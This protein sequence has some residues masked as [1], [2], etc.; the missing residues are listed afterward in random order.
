MSI[1]SVNLKSRLWRSKKF[2][3]ATH[4][5]E[6][7]KP[8][9]IRSLRLGNKA[10]VVVVCITSIIM[11]LSIFVVLENAMNNGSVTPINSTNPPNG[12]S[13]SQI[14]TV[15]N[16]PGTSNS[17]PGDLPR[18]ISPTDNSHRS[19]AAGIIEKAQVMNSSVWRAVAQQAWQYFQIGTGV[20]STTGLPAAGIGYNYFTD[21][22]LG[23]YVQAVLDAQKI[24][25]ITKD[26]DWGSDYRLD[27]AL[28]FLETRPL[29]E[30]TNYPFWFYQSNGENFEFQSSQS[31]VKVDAVDTGRLFIA[32]SNLKSY[33][34]S[35]AWSSKINPTRVDNIVLHGRSNYTALIPDVENEANSNS[36]YA[37]YVTCGFAAFWPEVAYVPSRILNNIVSSPQITVNTDGGGLVKLPNA[38]IS[39]EPLLNAVFELNPNS[40]DYTKLL[41]LTRQVY[42]AHQERHDLELYPPYVAF[43]EGNS[44]GSTFI[45]EWVVLPG[46]GTWKITKDDLT[47]YDINPIIYAKVSL[48]FLALYNT[49]FA[50]EMSVFVEQNL[51]TP[52]IG[53]GEGVDYPY[54][55]QDPMIKITNI[56]SNTNGMVLEAASYF[57]QAYP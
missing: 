18:W 48:G 14:P 12:P 8:V 7:K 20:D 15:T 27:K 2:S 34:P 4:P 6:K 38:P 30:T 57:I 49:S 24:G 21:W 16:K 32:L 33:N 53:W 35:A 5:E 40:A 43:S 29:N 52:T 42:L 3:R 9:K 56:G 51:P 39:C 13:P 26:G 11:V 47:P 50:K 23:V 25:L 17:P 28:T 31:T 55:A 45:Y 19:Q 41:N 37:Y 46:Y 44:Q 10:T 54:T 22:D 1:R 36:V